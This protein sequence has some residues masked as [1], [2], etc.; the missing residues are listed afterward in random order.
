MNPAR[1][2]TLAPVTLFRDDAHP[3]AKAERQLRRRF[4][5]RRGVGMGVG[6]GDPVRRGQQAFGKPRQ[7]DPADIPVALALDERKTVLFFKHVQNF[8]KQGFR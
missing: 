8:A 6:P 5:V 4:E 3:P 2:L 1:I 7:S